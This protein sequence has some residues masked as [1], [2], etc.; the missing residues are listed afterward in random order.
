MQDCMFIGLDVHNDSIAVS[1]APSDSTVVRRYGI[2]G[3]TL[4][5][6]RR[7]VLTGSAGLALELGGDSELTLEGLMAPGITGARLGGFSGQF[8]DGLDD[9]LHFLV[10]K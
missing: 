5:A 3:G 4:A 10:R 6:D 2:I 8:A 9:G 1:I 7:N